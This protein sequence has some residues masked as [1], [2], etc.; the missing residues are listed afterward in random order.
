[1]IPKTSFAWRL[2][3]IALA[4]SLVLVLLLW[5]AQ[6]QA[7]PVSQRS[8]P[9]PAL[10][11]APEVL[12]PADGLPDLIVEAIQFEPFHPLVGVTTTVRVRIANVGEGDVGAT[13]NFFVD[14]YVDPA[15]PPGRGTPGQ[16]G[17]LFQGVQGFHMRVGARLDLEFQYVFHDT[18]TYALFAQVDTDG[19]VVEAD[20]DNNVLGPVEA[21]VDTTHR[22]ADESH[23]DF[24]HGFSNLDLSYPQG[25]IALSGLFEEPIYEPGQVPPGSPHLHDPDFRVTEPISGSQVA[26][27]ITRDLAG[28][29]YVAWEEGENDEP[30]DRDIYCARSTDGGTTWS[31]AVR[32]NQDGPGSNQRTP[33]I[34]YDNNRG[35][36]YAVWQD[37]RHRHGDIYF[38]RSSD[39]GD[40]WEEPPWNPINDDLGGAD[41]L[42]PSMA[43]DDNGVVFLVWQDRRNGNDDVYFAA[44]GDGG[45][46]W[47]ANILVTDEPATTRQAQTS[48]SVAVG[49][50]VG[51]TIIYVVWE[52]GRRQAS[53]DP[54]DIYFVWGSECTG[55]DC[56]P[57]T[58][59]VDKRV[60]DAN[61]GVRA[62]QPTIATSVPP[63]VIS[64]TE[65]FTPGSPN[66]SP[67]LPVTTTVTFLAHYE[68]TAVHFAWQDFR[69]VSPDIYHAW[70][71]APFF[72]LVWVETLPDV[73]CWP[74]EPFEPVIPSPF[75]PD[76]PVFGNVRV[77]ALTPEKPD[78]YAPP[79]GSSGEWAIEPSWQGDPALSPRGEETDGVYIAWSDA[80]NFDDWNCQIYV[81]QAVRPD[82]QSP[83]YEVRANAVVNDNAHLTRYLGPQY[84]QL[85]PASVRQYRPALTY[86]NP[87]PLAEPYAPVP[88]V[89]WDDDRYDDPLS[90]RA[91]I[92]SIF[93]AR[94]GGPPFPGVS[95]VYISRVFDGGP[96]ARW[97]L[98]DWW[99]VTAY[100]TKILVQTRTGD[101]PWPDGSWSGWTGAVFDPQY[102]EWAYQAPGPIV[103]S[104]QQPYPQARY[105]QYKVLL[106]DCLD[107]WKPA[108]S[109]ADGRWLTTFQP[110]VWVDQVRI[111]YAPKQWYTWL[112]L[113]SES[114]EGE[115]P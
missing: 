92:R 7:V 32:V 74:A 75:G 19:N 88:Y 23:S 69:H 16:P 54:G 59:D 17:T 94:P 31:P 10:P 47:T 110:G 98:L 104:D 105:L 38:A 111:H 26:P 79:P 49:R 39:G 66:C 40:T 87:P 64:T 53:G 42:H 15:E 107:I 70:T 80:R 1:M 73:N 25:I 103:G 45:T 108:W 30:A 55:P 65:V 52:D 60:D 97:Y 6:V 113:S 5:Q 99:G 28:T 56:P 63:F 93:F 61:L 34:V 24:Q 91:R 12:G 89:V 67:P 78:D 48:P 85:R 27:S 62:A 35:M 58:F 86:H 29:L 46:S 84:D 36:L 101:T 83:D 20:E 51:E 37:L 22:F 82:D 9:T 81:A 95:G 2:P 90:G 18:H 13:N 33:K 43:V 72:D 57:Y 50:Q 112:P 41:Q 96:E 77:N 76:Y 21:A 3:L 109:H 71:F 11:S 100:G 14:L 115:T 114:W 102:H 44:S 4:L 106:F 68:G 8:T